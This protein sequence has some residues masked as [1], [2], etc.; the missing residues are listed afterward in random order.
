MTKRQRKRRRQRRILAGTSLSI[1]A[2]L[3]TGASAQ[4]VEYEVDTNAND[5]GAA[6][7]SCAPGGGLGECSL[8][9]AISNSNTQAGDDDVTFA[10]SLSGATITLGG[11]QIGITD[12]LNLNGPG[13]SNLTITADNDS[14]IFLVDM[15]TPGEDADITGLRLTDGNAVDGGAIYNVD[16]D[17][18]LYE[19]V[20]TGNTATDDGGAMFNGD[21]VYGGE[22]TDLYYTT[23]NGNFAGDDGGGIYAPVSAGD[24]LGSTVHGNTAT[25]TGGGV[26]TGGAGS[27][28][29][30]DFFNSTVTGNTGGGGNN[31]HANGGVLT[32][33]ES[34]IFADGGGTS[35][36][37]VTGLVYAD[38]SLIE[39]ATG[40]TITGANNVTGQDP[41][42]GPLQN[43]GGPTPTRR[44]AVG[45]PV[46]D[47]GSADDFTYTDQRGLER[48]IDV[49]NIANT[50]DGTDIGAFELS[51]SEAGYTPPTTGN[52]PG[53][54]PVTKKKKKCKK[55]KKKRSAA[56]AKKKKC[57][58]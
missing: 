15:V 8:R 39:N 1:G 28:F 36:P 18:N 7:T 33:I 54:T 29:D 56:A 34:S 13:A 38:F 44:P 5:A 31:L 6:L 25:G 9:G 2:S 53:T 23:I 32:E 55:K 42:L 52:P 49:P 16:A 51:L 27:S 4:A 58:K 19:V 41:V 40:A 21:A 11:T 47:K 43:N 17:A 24:V 12:G 30:T 35:G 14:R 46:I 57:K 20:M 37:D 48:T 45:S 10:S 3:V 50:D 26:A 22:S